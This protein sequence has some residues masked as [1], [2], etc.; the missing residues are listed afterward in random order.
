MLFSVACYGDKVMDKDL[1]C[2][3]Y[4]KDSKSGRKLIM[5]FVWLK[6]CEDTYAEFEICMC[7]IL[8]L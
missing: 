6:K 1:R 8:G 4:F 2:S 5:K 7:F 3:F